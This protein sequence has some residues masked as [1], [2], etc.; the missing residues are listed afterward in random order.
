MTKLVCLLVADRPLPHTPS[1]EDF[2]S[3]CGK[4]VWRALSSPAEAE[5][6]CNV[7]LPKEIRGEITLSPPSPE[8][9]DDIL[10]HL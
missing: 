4:A 2:C 9:I 8:Q 10:R 6:I 7:C 1:V 3:V 5:A